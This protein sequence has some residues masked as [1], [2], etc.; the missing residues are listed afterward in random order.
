MSSPESLALEVKMRDIYDNPEEFL[1]ADECERG[2][3]YWSDSS[4]IGQ[5]AL[6]A[7]FMERDGKSALTAI[8]LAEQQGELRLGFEYYKQRAVGSHK[9]YWRPHVALPWATEGTP[10]AIIEQGIEEYFSVGSGPA[11]RKLFNLLL[12]TEIEVTEEKINWLQT[13]IPKELRN[14]F[15]YQEL[16]EINQAN[17]AELEYLRDQQE[18]HTS[19]AAVDVLIAHAK[20]VTTVQ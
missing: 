17:L 13:S 14:T 11:C 16:V 19:S 2:V 20:S 7:G 3:I 15:A 18:S 5:V 10:D 9:G 4:E 6:C 12:A 1:P 8:G